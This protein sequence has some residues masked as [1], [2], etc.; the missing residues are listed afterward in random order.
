[1]SRRILIIISVIVLILL[2]LL[3]Y[4]QFWPRPTLLEI[5][6]DAFTTTDNTAV[7]G[8]VL[9][10][11][12]P[13]GGLTATVPP[14]QPASGTVILQPT[15]EFTYTPATDFVGSAA[16]TYEAC[17]TADPGQCGTATVTITVIEGPDAV[18]DAVMTL[19]N[20][21]AFG[22]VLANDLPSPGQMMA[23]A[24][25]TTTQ[26][27]GE[28]KLISTGNFIYT[29]T[30]DY[31]G[32]DQVTYQACL[33]AYPNYC[34]TAMV[35]I[36]VGPIDIVDDAYGTEKN[37]PVANNVLTNDSPSRL[38]QATAVMTT[39]Q[40]NGAFELLTSGD[41]IYTPAV[42]YVGS[43]Q[44]TYQ[45]C[46]KTDLTNCD[47]ATVIF[48][49]D[50]PVDAVDDVYS[51]GKNQPISRNVLANDLPTGKLTASS[52]E[53]DLNADGSFTYTPEPSFS[54]T[55]TFN[56]QACL[57]S[58]AT[59]CDSAVVTIDVGL[60]TQHVVQQG[61]WLLQIARCYGTSPESIVYANYIP[62][63]SWIM[64]G[65]VFVI[66]QVGDVSEPFNDGACIMW[67]TV[68]AGETLQSIATEYSVD[69]DMLIKAN[70]GCYGYYSY[71]PYGGYYGYGYGYHS[72]YIY[73]GCYYYGVPN[74]YAGQRLI[75]PVNN[76]N[77]HLRP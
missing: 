13:A 63:P 70:Y 60:V 16:F 46:L 17:L 36:T 65:D 61:E 10:N 35:M 40:A 39:T 18:D 22:D 44:V 30:L 57:I 29:P 21:A 49:V 68:E 19:K 56:Y 20:I 54:G 32:P 28:F 9:D 33:A 37:Q 76:E 45:A 4:W 12:T 3:V 24:I 27:N 69:L 41:F 50:P 71:Y 7:P 38:L 67:S 25:M 31:E 73:S 8:N 52:T 15:G 23:T 64:F 72:P 42:D 53:F 77:K 34:D 59:K 5:V 11:D 66:P 2:C 74:V 51:T 55:V 58:D 47:T 26:A 48:T 75:I 43:D 1:M 6:D 62:Y 14:Q